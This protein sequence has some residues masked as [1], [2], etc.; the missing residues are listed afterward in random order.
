MP[1]LRTAL[2]FSF[3]LLSA[4]ASMAGEFCAGKSDGN[5]ADPD[6]CSQFI[7]CAAGGLIEATMSCPGG[8][9][10]NDEGLYCDWPENVTCP[11]DVPTQTAP[12]DAYVCVS[13][14]AD[15][16]SDIG[17]GQ[18]T[19]PSSD[20]PDHFSQDA[21]RELCDDDADC[22]AFNVFDLGGYGSLYP[23]A[24]EGFMWLKSSLDG[25]RDASQ[26]DVGT[27]C[28]HCPR[29]LETDA[30]VSEDA[31]ARCADFAVSSSGD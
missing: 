6:D 28:Y 7:S 26:A 22:V 20:T 5:Y 15:W 8:L 30:S 18:M 4:S 9:Q 24:P 21:S 25:E 19:D 17:H 11:A 3:S 10:W 13:G 2:L 16:G 14:V 23:A 31:L 1:N 12:E 27:L 29:I